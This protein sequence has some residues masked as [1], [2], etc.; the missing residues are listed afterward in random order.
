MKIEVALNHWKTSVLIHLLFDAKIYEP[1]FVCHLQDLRS[2]LDYTTTHGTLSTKTL[3]FDLCTRAQSPISS[4][5]L[6]DILTLTVRE[7]AGAMNHD[8][9]EEACLSFANFE[10]NE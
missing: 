5:D 8:K 4:L 6:F 3:Q 7:Y 2:W 10:G 9:A 1:I